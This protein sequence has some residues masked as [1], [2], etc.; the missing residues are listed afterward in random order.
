MREKCEI[1][2]QQLLTATVK[3]KRVGFDLVYDV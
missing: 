2:G 3:I 1:L